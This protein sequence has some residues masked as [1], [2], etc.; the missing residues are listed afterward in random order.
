MTKKEK[1]R[2]NIDTNLNVSLSTILIKLKV[3]QNSF[4]IFRL[5]IYN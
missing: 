3:N 1:S 2:N 4:Y 5:I